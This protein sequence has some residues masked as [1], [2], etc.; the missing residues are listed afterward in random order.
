MKHTKNFE[1]FIN[2]S[3]TKFGDQVFD[4]KYYDAWNEMSPAESRRALDELG[5]PLSWLGSTF[6]EFPPSEKARISKW[7]DDNGLPT[8]GD[9]ESGLMFVPRG[10]ADATRMQEALSDSDLHAEWNAREGYFYFQEDVENYDAL[11][12]E[13]MRLADE[14]GVNGYVEGIW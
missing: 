11:E 6:D 14:H 7:M 9:Q 5:L 1:S 2:E 8:K 13:I 12:A 10:S 4:D 3:R